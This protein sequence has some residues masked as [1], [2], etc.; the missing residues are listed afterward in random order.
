MYCSGSA[1]S[2]LCLPA[3]TLS[4]LFPL[5]Q[6]SPSE[7][8]INCADGLLGAYLPQKMRD[9]F[10]LRERR[11]DASAIGPLNWNI[12]ADGHQLDDKIIGG[13]HGHP[14]PES[15]AGMFDR[16]ARPCLQSMYM[17]ASLSQYADVVSLASVLC[18]AK[19]SRY[20]QEGGRLKA[21]LACNK[22]IL[23]K[24]VSAVQLSLTAHGGA[25]TCLKIVRVD[26]AIAL[27]QECYWPRCIR[28]LSTQQCALWP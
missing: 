18:A 10:L 6:L 12:S 13:Y 11:D 22:V 9:F 27:L 17:P 24:S 25:Q 7:L 15:V 3:I 26:T 1:V 28:H 19:G 14:G 5:Q 21:S 4:V 20:F 2:I 8:A 16:T 23:L